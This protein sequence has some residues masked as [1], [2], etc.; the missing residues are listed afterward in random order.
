MIS[1]FKEN[2]LPGIVQIINK[3]V[4]DKDTNIKEISIVLLGCIAENRGKL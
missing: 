3:K 4:K 1:A 2:I